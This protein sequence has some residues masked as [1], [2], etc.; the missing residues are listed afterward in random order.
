MHKNPTRRDSLSGMIWIRAAHFDVVRI[1]WNQSSL[2][3]FAS[4]QEIA[5]QKEEEPSIRI[6]SEFAVEKKGLRFPSK[7][8]TEMAFVNKEGKR[9]VRARITVTYTHYKFFTVETEID[10]SSS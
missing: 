3:N 2:G 10:Y 8:I 6:V 1:E 7:T 9:D 4:I 5:R